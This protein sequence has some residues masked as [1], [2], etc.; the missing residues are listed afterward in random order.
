[1]TYPK[2]P[3]WLLRIIKQWVFRTIPSRQ[4][5]RYRLGLVKNSAQNG[6]IVY[7]SVES[8]YPLGKY[9]VK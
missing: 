8:D 4:N 1:M 2:P 7:V 9:W 5:C 6:T 3:Y